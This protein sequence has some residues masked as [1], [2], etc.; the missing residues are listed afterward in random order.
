MKEEPGA[1]IIGES[2]ARKRYDDIAAQG[3]EPVMWITGHSLIKTKMKET[4]AALAGEM[5]GHIFYKH[6]YY[7]FDDATYAAGRLLEILG[8]T[9]KS[10]TELLSDVPETVSTPEIRMDC[11]ENIKFKLVDK[12]IDAF[13]ERSNEERFPSLISMAPGSNGK[14]DG[15]LYVVAIRSQFL[16][17]DLRPRPRSGFKNSGGDGSRD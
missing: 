7:G 6:R 9:T 10:V 14:T 11:P 8:Y 12:V 5:S 13:K 2:N 1:V 3:G 16:F 4:N 17:C 15:A